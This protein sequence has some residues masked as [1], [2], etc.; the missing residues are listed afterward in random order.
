MHEGW[1]MGKVCKMGTQAAGAS[2]GTSWKSKVAYKNPIEDTC[3]PLFF[4][5]P[6][7]LKLVISSTVIESWLNTFQRNVENSCKVVLGASICT[8][9]ISVF[10]T[11][12][13][14]L[15]L[16]L[17]SG[18]STNGLFKT[19]VMCLYLEELNEAYNNKKH[20]VRSQVGLPIN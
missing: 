13:K 17:G 10:Q 14:F 12:S 7:K 15:A 20:N 6:S 2:C 1:C 4:N 19:V 18:R 5:L 8:L 3:S 16:M 9:A 11:R